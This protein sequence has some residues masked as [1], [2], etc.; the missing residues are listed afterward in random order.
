LTSRGAVFL[1]LGKF[2]FS[3]DTIYDTFICMSQREKILEKMKNN[4]RDWRID[5]LKAQ[6]DYFGIQWVHDGT[7]HCVFDFGEV[8]LCVPAKR[9][10]KPIY[11]KQF[12]MLIEK[13]RGE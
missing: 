5:I 8:S 4:P 10:I 3:I 6:A 12:V 11:I 1:I 9:P 7:S 2:P 13:V